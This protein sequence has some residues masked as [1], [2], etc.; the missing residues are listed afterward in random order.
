MIKK[1]QVAKWAVMLWLQTD[2]FLDKLESLWK[3][4]VDVQ[5]RYLQILLKKTGDSNLTNR[6]LPFP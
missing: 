1:N 6:I 4:Q 3:K 5:Q 2:C